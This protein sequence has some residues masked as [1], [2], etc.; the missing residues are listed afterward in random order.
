M[1][2]GDETTGSAG[3]ADAA[4]GGSRG[5]GGGGGGD[6]K[7]HKQKR[8]AQKPRPAAHVPPADLPLPEG[9]LHVDGSLLEGGGQI[10]RNSSALCA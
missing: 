8:G 3:A 6:Q 10:L 9:G 2:V 1:E 5:G 4:K 7:R